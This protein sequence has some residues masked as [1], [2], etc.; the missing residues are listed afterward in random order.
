MVMLTCRTLH[1]S[2]AQ[3]SA[4]VVT[5]PAANDADDL[6]VLCLVEYV[7]GFLDEQSTQNWSKTEHCAHWL[8]VRGYNPA[9]NEITR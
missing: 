7:T 5:R 8:K 2:R 4:T 3:S 9:Y 1:F 6:I